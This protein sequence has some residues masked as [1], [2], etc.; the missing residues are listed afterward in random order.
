MDLAFNPLSKLSSAVWPVEKSRCLSRKKT[1]QPPDK[2]IFVNLVG[3]LPVHS[4]CVVCARGVRQ[5]LYQ[6]EDR[7]KR[8]YNT[9]P[10]S[11]AIKR[12][13]KPREA[14]GTLFRSGIQTQRPSIRKSLTSLVC[15]TVSFRMRFRYRLD[16]T[17]TSSILLGIS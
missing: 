13:A 17:V 4:F 5:C 1:F 12:L 16:V 15:G 2:V 11:E 7:N 14:F 6:P 10:Q 8:V 9:L 3:S